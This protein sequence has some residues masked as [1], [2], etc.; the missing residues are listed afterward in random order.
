MP[1]GGARA[2]SGPAASATSERAGRNA[3]EQTQRRGDWVE[4]PASYTGKAPTFPLDGR[5][6]GEAKLW[7]ALWRRPQAAQWVR[8]GLVYQVAHYCRL[9]LQ[10]TEPGAPA[11]L[12]T[13]VLRQEDSLGLSTIGLAALRWRIV[14]DEVGAARSA[15][16]EPA[17][18]RPAPVRRLRPAASE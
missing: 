14:E 12:T 15:R 1:A 11:S 3:R 8:L 10:A 6:P 18:S 13:A 9:Y 2:R 4:L 7:R 17:A 5:T 16:A